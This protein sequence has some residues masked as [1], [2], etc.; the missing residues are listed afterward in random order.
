MWTRQALKRTSRLPLLAA[1]LLFIAG[2]D[3]SADPPSV[4]IVGGGFIFNYRL[5]EVYYGFVA[6]VG[7]SAPS[8]AI[9]E[10]RFENP[11]GGDDIV[12]RQMI[13]S[14]RKR[15]KFET[16]PLRGV[17]AGRS[18]RVE[19]LLIDPA[20]NTAIASASRSFQSKVGSDVLP[21][22]PLTIGPGYHNMP[23]SEVPASPPIK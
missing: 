21:T 8:D 7:A 22:R 20:G 1:F 13:R 14:E 3:Q 12:Q 10:A 19:L 16:P 5:A 4:E 2:C 23:V 6:T 11:E 18:Y 9:L 15:Y 17:Q